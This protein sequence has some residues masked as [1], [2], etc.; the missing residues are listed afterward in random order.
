MYPLIFK[1]CNVAKIPHQNP[2]F[3]RKIHPFQWGN[4]L[5]PRP[6]HSHY[7]AACVCLGTEKNAAGQVTQK[8]NVMASYPRVN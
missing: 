5:G 3:H 6:W 7:E 2:S 8:H 1:H 4:A